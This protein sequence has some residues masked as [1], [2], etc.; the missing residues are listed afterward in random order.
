MPS[1]AYN[2]FWKNHRQV[3]KFLEAYDFHNAN[4]KGRK[5]L[6]HFTRAALV[7]LC[8]AFEVY[9]E[10][11]TIE[12]S[13]IVIKSRKTPGELPKKIQKK[14]SNYVKNNK[15][16]N[17][18]IY[19]ANDWKQYYQDLVKT[20]TKSLNTPKQNKITELFEHY[21]GIDAKIVNDK[22]M[23]SE[24]DEII[25]LRGE[26]AHNVVAKQYLKKQSVIEHNDIICKVVKDIDRLFYDELADDLGKRPWQNTSY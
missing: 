19:F 24:I 26:I 16:E 13:K 11:I 2:E 3:D 4:K 15:D 23:L 17:E 10:Q 5:S 25:A 14:I 8:S 6:D 21:L 9:I 7:F 1:N 18:P 20:Q 12:V 22:V